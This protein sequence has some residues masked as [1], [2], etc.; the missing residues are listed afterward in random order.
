MADSLLT[1]DV[2]KLAQEMAAGKFSDTGRTP[3]I[4]ERIDSMTGVPLRT[5][6]DRAQKGRFG[7]G[8]IDAA[9]SIGTDPQRSPNTEQ[10]TEQAIP[11]GNIYGKALLK[12]SLD[13]ADPLLL[14]PGGGEAK[15]GATIRGS[16]SFGRP[17]GGLGKS[18][19]EDVKPFTPKYK[20]GPSLGSAEDL[21]EKA[22]KQ[23]ELLTSTQSKLDS[24]FNRATKESAQQGIEL[25]SHPKFSE[26]QELQNLKE[27]LIKGGQ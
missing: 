17:T 22:Y 8:L 23:K 25:K 27:K 13:I 10:L 19:I 16:K 11:N 15:L 5:F 20:Q 3:D 6:I 18:I 14:V 24:L 7:Q 26:I 9:S 12:T 1:R 4:G 2:N 21:A